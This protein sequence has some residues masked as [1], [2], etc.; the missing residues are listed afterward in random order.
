MYICQNVKRRMH[1]QLSI[2]HNLWELIVWNSLPKNTRKVNTIKFFR[3]KLVKHI[4]SASDKVDNIP[5]HFSDHEDR[6]V[7]FDLYFWLMRHISY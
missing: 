5:T 7:Y 1:G 4:S 6:I 3:G 2:S